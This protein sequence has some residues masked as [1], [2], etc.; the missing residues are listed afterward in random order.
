MLWYGLWE[1]G[2]AKVKKKFSGAQEDKQWEFKESQL[3]PIKWAIYEGKLDFREESW[4]DDPLV[5][6]E[7][8][9]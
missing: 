6:T 8:A 3:G 9:L 2:W 1:G 4:E 7:K 5:H